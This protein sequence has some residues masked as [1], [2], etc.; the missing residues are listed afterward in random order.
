M[1]LSFP[2]YTEEK[3]ENGPLKD[4]TAMVLARIG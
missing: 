2:F 3:I 1:V 4:F